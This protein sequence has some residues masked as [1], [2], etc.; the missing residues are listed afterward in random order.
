MCTGYK[1]FEKFVKSLHTPNVKVFI[2]VFKQKMDSFRA[3]SSIQKKK[4]KKKER[5]KKERK[6]GKKNVRSYE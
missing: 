2:C 6:K 4:K 1:K 3:Y 5:K